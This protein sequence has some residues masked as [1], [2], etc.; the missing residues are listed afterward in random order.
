M[1]SDIWVWVGAFLTIGTYSNLF[2]DNPVYRALESVF[3]ALLAGHAVV[4]NWF[5]FQKPTLSTRLMEGGEYALLIPLFLA[6]L[7]YFRYSKKYAWLARYSMSFMMGIGA[8]YVLTKDLKPMF[9]SQ[10][11]A[12]M[13]PLWV[14]DNMGTTINNWFIV[15][16]VV[17][18]LMYFFFTVKKT[19]P[20]KVFGNAGRV[21]L[22]VAFGAL[23]GD[24]VMGRISVTLVRFQFLLKDWLGLVR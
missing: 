18:V 10:A 13:L 24:T 12:T 15:A 6:A 17:C 23:F 4:I 1:S 5:N 8:A 9:L 7:M 16:G 19:G 21:F 14:P 2:K 11:R 3:V 20:I 22:M